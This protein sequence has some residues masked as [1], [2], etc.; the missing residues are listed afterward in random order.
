[1]TGSARCSTSWKAHRLARPHAPRRRTVLVP[2]ATTSGKYLPG[3]KDR[4]SRRYGRAAVARVNDQAATH[5]APMVRTI[6]PGTW[7]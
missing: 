6:A 5:T 1:M 2:M 7:M 4:Q 3:A